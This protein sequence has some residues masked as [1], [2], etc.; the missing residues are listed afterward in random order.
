MEEELIG[1]D[2]WLRM[3]LVGCDNDASRRLDSADVSSDAAVRALHGAHVDLHASTLGDRDAVRAL[4]ES[5][6]DVIVPL[7]SSRVPHDC[8]SPAYSGVTR[9]RAFAITG[10]LPRGSADS[11][12]VVRTKN[13]PTWLYK[14]ASRTA[15][16]GRER[17]KRS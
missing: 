14:F 9:T 16:V 10:V 15:G 17:G 4:D 11:W 12:N 13:R 5:V 1:I 8:G 7:L 3:R 2:G 6:L